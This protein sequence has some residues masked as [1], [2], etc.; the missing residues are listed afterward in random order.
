MPTSIES[1]LFP[2]EPSPIMLPRPDGTSDLVVVVDHAGRGIPRRLGD[3]GLS[4]ADLLRHIAWDIGAWAVAL[5]LAERLDAT[6]IGQAYSRLVIDC[7]RDP[8]VES[9]IAG[10]SEVTVIPGNTALSVADAAARRTAVFDPYHGRIRMLLEA[11]KAQGRRTVL[12]ALHSMTNVYKGVQRP[13]QCAVLFGRDDRFARCVLDAFRREAGLRVGEN[14]PYSVSDETDY[15]IPR[16]GEARGLPHVEI[17]MRQDLIVDEQG[18]IE[19]AERLARVLTEA[20][21]AFLEQT[22]GR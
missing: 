19:W 11:R 22:D 5:R 12:I 14:E 6:L 21:A 9:A 16:H 1:F 3:L 18:Q 7:N 10:L 13:M 17:E 20:D 8:T 4:E 15:T 2:D